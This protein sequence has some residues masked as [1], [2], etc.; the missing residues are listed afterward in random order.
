[1]EIKLPSVVN[2]LLLFDQEVYIMKKIFILMGCVVLINGCAT[3]SKS[4]C[5]GADDYSR[6][7]TLGKNDGLEG[8]MPQIEKRGQACAKHNIKINRD[9]YIVGYK[10]GLLAYCQPQNILS[11]ALLG[12]GQ[13]Q[14]SW[15]QAGGSYTNCP[16]SRHEEL[17]S[18]Y[19]VGNNYYQAKT[20]LDG[21]EKGIASAKSS[22]QKND[23]KQDMRDYYRG[24]VSENSELLPSARNTLN[25]AKRELIQFKKQ[26]GLN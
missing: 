18:Y 4:E 9:S 16:L 3:M 23:L 24:K 19:D 5:L 7:T 15:L 25:E 22:L 26:N 2:Q 13:G 11:L 17:R 12:K 1:M 10:E 21:L 6:W 14:G 8:K 20:Q